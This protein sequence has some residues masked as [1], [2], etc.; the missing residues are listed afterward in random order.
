MIHVIKTKHTHTPK[1]YE[2]GLDFIVKRNARHEDERMW[3]E[4]A[5][6]ECDEPAYVYNDENNGRIEVFRNVVSH[7]HTKSTSHLEL[8]VYYG[9]RW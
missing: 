4:Q 5:R 9:N 6:G 3:I 2:A 7:L 8:D 1:G